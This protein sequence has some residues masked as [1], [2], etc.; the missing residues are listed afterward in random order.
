MFDLN[1]VAIRFT[2]EDVTP[3]LDLVRFLANLIQREADG[4]QVQALLPQL[5]SVLLHQCDHHAAHIVVV[6]GVYQLHLE[7]RVGPKC[8]CRFDD[9]DEEGWKC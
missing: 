5:S 1:L 6:I 3:G 8:V 4:L 7:L 9:L 2:Q